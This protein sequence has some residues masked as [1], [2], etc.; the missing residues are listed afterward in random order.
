LISGIS[1][2]SS[3]PEWLVLEKG[4]ALILKIDNLNDIDISAWNL[5]D[6]IE[7]FKDFDGDFKKNRDEL[8]KLEDL[9]TNLENRYFLPNA[10]LQNSVNDLDNLENYSRSDEIK[11]DLFDLRDSPGKTGYTGSPHIFRPRINLL[12]KALEELAL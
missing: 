3:G 10:N 8:Y 4:G 5:I 6:G 11:Q 12:A 9:L 1:Y 2:N 7:P